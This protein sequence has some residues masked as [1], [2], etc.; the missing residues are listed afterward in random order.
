MATVAPGAA[1]AAAG[2]WCWWMDSSWKAPA[3]QRELGMD[4]HFQQLLQAAC[5]GWFSSRSPE[6]PQ[7]GV[8]VIVVML[9]RQG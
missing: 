6:W 9:L 7:R 4:W 2:T 5:A 3:G 1:P 8:L